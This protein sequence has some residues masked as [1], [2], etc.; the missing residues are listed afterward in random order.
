[1][2]VCMHD[3]LFVCLNRYTRVLMWDFIQTV[4][5]FVTVGFNKCYKTVI[6]IFH[7]QVILVMC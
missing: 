6:S 3:G 1:M 5:P 4:K 2:E 7:L